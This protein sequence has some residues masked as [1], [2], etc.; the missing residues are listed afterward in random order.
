[1][2]KEIGLGQE[3]KLK[4]K[5]EFSVA[6]ASSFQQNLSDSSTHSLEKGQKLDVEKRRRRE[7][8]S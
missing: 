1:V 5:E 4:E 7:F 3:G 6:S 8:T 2:Q